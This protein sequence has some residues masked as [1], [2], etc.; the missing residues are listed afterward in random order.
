MF[1][2]DGNGLT[3]IDTEV[4]VKNRLVESSEGKIIQRED[5]TKK[6]NE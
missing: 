4:K 5:N 6:L 2:Y 3:F 1:L